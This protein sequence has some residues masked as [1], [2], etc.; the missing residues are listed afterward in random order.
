MFLC[1]TKRYEII[2]EWIMRN[3][4]LPQ[5][6]KLLFSGWTN[7][8]PVNPYNLPETNVYNND[9]EF[10]P[11]WI[12]CGGNCLDCAVNGTG[13]WNATNGQTIAFKIH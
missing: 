11:E 1:F 6:L 7:L 13:C 8:K 2:N 10:D 4:K 3:K 9:S 12:P 5:N